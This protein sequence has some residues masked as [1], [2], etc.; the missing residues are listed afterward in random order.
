ME[1]KT[2]LKAVSYE[3]NPIY[4]WGAKREELF[5]CPECFGPVVLKKGAVKVAHFAH[6]P[7]STCAFA[8]G[9]S[10]EHLRMKENLIKILRKKYLAENIDSEVRLAPNRRADVVLKLSDIP[11]VFECQ[12]SPITV[13]DLWQRTI[14]YLN[15]KCN[16]QWI[17]HISRIK[18]N[19]FYE[20]VGAVRIPEEIRFLD[21]RHQSLYFMDDDGHIRR[22]QLKYKWAKGLFN[23]TT[24]TT[25]FV[26]FSKIHLWELIGGF[27]DARVNP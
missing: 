14:D 8:E 7:G 21:D 13:N 9:E 3:G 22:G 23:T 16:I 12:V 6:S 24:K 10:W 25:C 4:A 2:L 11:W 1:A 17:F 19:S 18:R 27:P 15:A 5:Y 20:R 26:N